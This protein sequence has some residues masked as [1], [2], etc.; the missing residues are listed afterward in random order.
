MVEIVWWVC[1]INSD[2]S[3]GGC[4]V[5]FLCAC[6]GE[7]SSAFGAG[8]LICGEAV[9][10]LLVA[11]CGVCHELVEKYCKVVGDFSCIGFSFPAVVCCCSCIKKVLSCSL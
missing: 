1:W 3:P 6:D 7:C 9:V 5:V 4:V 10:G 8:E 2:A 11:L